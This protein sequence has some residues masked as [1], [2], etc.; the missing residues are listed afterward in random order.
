ML[1]NCFRDD[2]HSKPMN[3][4]KYRTTNP[5]KTLTGGALV[6]AMAASVFAQEKPFTQP[7]TGQPPSPPPP[8]KVAAPADAAAK[9]APAQPPPEPGALE[10]FFNGKLPEAIAKGKFNLNARLRYEYVDQNS[11]PD[12]SNALTLRT[13][14]G[15]TTAP[16]FGFTA[17][18]EGENVTALAPEHNYNAAGSNNEPT[19]PVVADPTTTELNQAWLAYSYTNIASAKLGRQR[20]ALDN[21]RFIGDV[22]W[23]QNMQTFDAATAQWTPLKDL[24]LFY[25]YVWEVNRVFGDVDGLPATSPNK[26]FDSDSHLINVSYAPCSFGRF[27]GYAYLLDLELNNGTAAEA[28]NSCATYGAYFAGSA[29]VT[30]KLALGYRAEFAWQSDYADSALSYETEYYNL[31]LS[32]NIKPFAFGAG[33]EVLGSD[34]GVGFKTPLATLHAFNGWADVFLNTPNDGLRDIYIFGQIT[35]PANIPLRLV[36]H[37]Y[38]A[39]SGSDD[40]GQEFDV[41]ASKKLGKHW[42]ALLKYSFYDGDDAAPPAVGVSD[43]EVH[44][45]WAQVE[46]NF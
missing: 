35:L 27:V 5:M 6:L 2:N 4:Q 19:R 37:R 9:P 41:I 46:F 14:F 7:G 31:E 18:L 30:E 15:Y 25:S 26:D 34:N 21:H 38:E 36:Y 45:F 28:N 12:E 3:N 8:P 22:G 39:D 40:Y 17:M 16:L 42:T 23:R 33:Y 32:G 13:R 44:K 20:I 1:T 11:L 29:P 43:L 10:K 24:N